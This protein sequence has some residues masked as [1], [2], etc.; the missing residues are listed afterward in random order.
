MGGGNQIKKITTNATAVYNNA[1][2]VLRESKF[3]DQQ[4]KTNSESNLF[5]KII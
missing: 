1:S 3:L 4:H 2:A 5:E